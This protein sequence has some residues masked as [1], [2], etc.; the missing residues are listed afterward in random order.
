VVGVGEGTPVIGFV[1]AFGIALVV[2]QQ[3]LGGSAKPPGGNFLKRQLSLS[4]DN[5]SWL[6]GWWRIKSPHLLFTAGCIGM[7]LALGPQ[8]FSGENLRQLVIGILGIGL[9]VIAALGFVLLK[10]DVKLLPEKQLPSDAR[11]RDS[12]AKRDIWGVLTENAFLVFAGSMALAWLVNPVRDVGGFEH[13]WARA[14]FM[15]LP[16]MLAATWLGISVRHRETAST[17]PKPWI[18]PTAEGVNVRWRMF[19]GAA[20]LVAVLLVSVGTWVYGEKRTTPDVIELS[21]NS[22]I[23]LESG[24]LLPTDSL[25]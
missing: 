22:Y 19:L 9:L 13:Y 25:P 21:G 5:E 7:L 14:L 1:V 2:G 11:S 8:M 3:L 17:L 20:V 23:L 18:Q 24:F 10:F 6:M 12:A 15:G 16:V 4:L